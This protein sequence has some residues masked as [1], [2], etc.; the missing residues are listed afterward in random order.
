MLGGFEVCLER[1]RWAFTRTLSDYDVHSDEKP[2]KICR[3][4]MM[5]CGSG[6]KDHSGVRSHLRTSSSSFQ[7]EKRDN[8]AL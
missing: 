5:H 8:F 6:D 3:L 4:P 1:G 7:S 2:K